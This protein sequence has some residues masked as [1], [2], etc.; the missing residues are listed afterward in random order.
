MVGGGYCR[1]QMPLKHLASGGQWLG[2]GWAPWRGGG[3]AVCRLVLQAL[4][5]RQW[6]PD[7]KPAGGVIGLDTPHSGQLTCRCHPTT[8]WGTGAAEPCT[9]L[10]A[11]RPP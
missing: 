4:A 3:G 9:R 1:L 10:G 6:A 7:A 2:V 8:A 11:A 5:G